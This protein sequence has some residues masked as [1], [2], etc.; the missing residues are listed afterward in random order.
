MNVTEQSIYE[1]FSFWK[2]ALAIEL[3]VLNPE[4]LTIVVGC[5]TSFYLAQTAS[6]LLNRHGFRSQPVA[7]S[8]WTHHAS[9]YTP[10]TV[11]ILALSRSGESTETIEAVE[12]S[13]VKGYPVIGITCEKGSTLERISDFPVY[14][15]THVREGIVMTSSA[16]LML[17]LSLRLAG[18]QV[19]E[20]DVDR[21]EDFLHEASTQLDRLLQDRSHFVYLGGGQFY[22]IANEGALKLQEMSLSYTQAYHPLEYRHGPITL[23]DER[24]LTVL[25]YNAETHALET[26]LTGD[27]QSKGARVIGFGGPG[28]LS[29]PY[30]TENPEV[31]PLLALPVL[32]LMG[33]RVAQLKGLDTTQPRHL[34]KV[35][36]LS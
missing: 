20:A 3:P 28:D 14:A 27:L 18:I 24:T 6:A 31:A 22:G 32:Q 25:L 29:L 10:E 30:P 21:A 5:G 17:L 9:S 7:G 26:R 35:V 8:E 23:V 15:A 12:Y 4:K 19:S 11:Q 13:K 2:S 16:S 1:Q 34:T 33:E 36:V